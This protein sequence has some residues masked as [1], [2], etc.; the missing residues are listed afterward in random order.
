MWSLL[1]RSLY[2][3]H[4]LAYVVLYRYTVLVLSAAF[5]LIGLSPSVPK[6]SDQTLADFSVGVLLI[7]FYFYAGRSPLWSTVPHQTWGIFLAV[8][9]G[10]LEAKLFFKQNVLLESLQIFLSVSNMFCRVQ[11]IITQIFLKDLCRIFPSML[12]LLL[13]FP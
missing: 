10:F 1:L 4:E 8:P 11:P 13:G 9:H 6:M 12:D 3:Q 5:D 7:S 2:V